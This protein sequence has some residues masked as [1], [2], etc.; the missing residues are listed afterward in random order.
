MSTHNNKHG[1]SLATAGKIDKCTPGGWH[2][3][4]QVCGKNEKLVYPLVV[5]PRNVELLSKTP[6]EMPKEQDSN[7]RN[8][9]N[10][11]GAT[12]PIDEGA[13]ANRDMY[14]QHNMLAFCPNFVPQA[15]D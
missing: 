14:V 5:E 2:I 12:P 3:L 13:L 7:K 4:S 15:R 8:G 9:S 6:K 11:V 1:R 10:D